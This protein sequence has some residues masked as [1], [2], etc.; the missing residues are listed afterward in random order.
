MTKTYA[1]LVGID[2]NNAGVLGGI[3]DIM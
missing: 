2:E 3:E 1:L